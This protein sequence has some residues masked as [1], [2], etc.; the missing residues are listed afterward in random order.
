LNYGGIIVTSSIIALHGFLG[1]PTD[2]ALLQL[3]GLYALDI[4]ATSISHLRSWARRFNQMSPAK[5]VLLGYSMGGRLA[6]HCLLDDP[7]KYRAAIILAAHPGIKNN[8]ER[9]QRLAI[10]LMWAHKFS[11]LS[12]GEVI[13]SWNQAPIFNNTSSIARQE[14]DFSRR[15]LVNALWYF[16]LGRQEFLLPLINQLPMPI[17]WLAPRGEMN[18][19]SN[20]A[21]KHP[22]SKII[23][24]DAGGHR[25]PFLESFKTASLIKDF[26][27]L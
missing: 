21:L 9:N 27:Q 18:K 23:E 16:S 2:F 24:M 6:L 14:Y 19:I 11:N 22:A 10:D 20:M 15:A 12:W 4:W 8:R 1:K 7:K 13:H 17:L 3:D 5:T 25:F 26:L